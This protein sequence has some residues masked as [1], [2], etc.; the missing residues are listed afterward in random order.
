[1]IRKPSGEKE[2]GDIGLGSSQI[3]SQCGQGTFPVIESQHHTLKN[4]Q[5]K[6]DGCFRVV[7][8]RDS[9]EKNVENTSAEE[10]ENQTMEKFDGENDHGEKMDLVPGEIPGTRSSMCVLISLRLVLQPC[11]K[12]QSMQRR[13]IRQCRGRFP[14]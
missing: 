8:V 11:R 1:M 4:N 7:S 12:L 6:G 9:T 14:A 13:N 5:N 2:A 10:K 3:L